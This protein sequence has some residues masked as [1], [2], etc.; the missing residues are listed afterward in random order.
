MTDLHGQGGSAVTAATT[1]ALRVNVS[2]VVAIGGN[3]AGSGRHRHF[4]SLT[5][6]TARSAHTDTEHQIILAGVRRQRIGVAAG[7]ATAADAPERG[8]R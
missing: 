8:S 2:G 1:E 3:T 6:V 7:T 5:T 4:S